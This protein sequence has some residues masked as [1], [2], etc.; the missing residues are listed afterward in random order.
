VIAAGS[1]ATA[2]LSTIMGAAVG[3]L[4]CEQVTAVVG[5]LVLMFIVQLLIPAIEKTAADFTPV[6][7]ASAL[8]GQSGSNLAPD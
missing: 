2:A 7:A 8:A 3:A 4:P 6:G 5:A 1:L